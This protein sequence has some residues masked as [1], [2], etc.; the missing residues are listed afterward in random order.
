VLGGGSPSECRPPPEKPATRVRS[1]RRCALW[2]PVPCREGS[3]DAIDRVSTIL[4]AIGKKGF[5]AGNEPFQANA[6]KLG[7]NFYFSRQ[8]KGWRRA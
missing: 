7:G 2:P 6:L 1:V 8:L 4:A 3:V 5:T